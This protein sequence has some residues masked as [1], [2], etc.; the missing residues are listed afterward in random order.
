VQFKTFNE[1]VATAPS[2]NPANAVHLGRFHVEVCGPE[3]R[4]VSVAGTELLHRL[5][6]AVRDDGWR[7]VSPFD[8]VTSVDQTAETL[9]LEMSAR[10]LAPGLD[11]AASA[12]LSLNSAGELLAD[13]R[14]LARRPS[15]YNRI[16]WCL[17]ARTD[18]AVGATLD[19]VREDGAFERLLLPASIVPQRLIGGLPAPIHGPVS[20]LTLRYP[21]SGGAIFEF[22]GDLFETEDQ[23]NWGDATF[24]IYSTPLALRAPHGVEAGTE[25][26]QVVQGQLFGSNASRRTE[27]TGDSPVIRLGGT[28]SPLFPPIGL[29]IAAEASSNDEERRVLRALRPAY[30]RVVVAED[31]DRWPER[32]ARASAMCAEISC[33]LEVAAL[34]RNE[35]SAF[36]ASVG[37]ILSGHDGGVRVLLAREGAASGDG[38][39]VTPDEL[40]QT[41]L[42]NLP[43]GM[44]LAF[45]S[46]LN[47]CEL[48]RTASL[49][50]RHLY[51]RVNAQVHE[52]ESSFVLQTPRVLAEQVASARARWGP[53]T[54]TVS[55]LVF[56]AAPDRRLGEATGAVWIAASMKYLAEAG[57]DG[58]SLFDPGAGWSL[59]SF[60]LDES[61][62]G[63]LTP[64][65]HTVSHL[66]ALRAWRVL[67]CE[68]SDPDSVVGL[69]AESNGMTE[70]VLANLNS[71]EV[72]TTVDWVGRGPQS[73]S[74][75]IDSSEARLRVRAADRSEIEVLLRPYEVVS[76]R[77]GE[78]I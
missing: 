21:Q 9:T 75:D 38:D 19:G 26:R 42:M 28:A 7:T 76:L 20:A 50:G 39:E 72:V 56:A 37:E 49:G 24:K 73:E 6:V 40:Y 74:F 69:A 16:G 59:S 14:W 58:V 78:A 27:S 15:R 77:G 33:G 64:A 22:A 61:A 10:Y 65:A 18:L 60:L 5:H 54:L 1:G 68:S 3:F 23:R 62:V 31:E 44:R 25:V 29:G 70:V 17:L 48:N 4:R 2:V 43:A 13:L 66:C 32:L 55:P 45:G 53:E 57:V 41:A 71:R 12:T 46:N 8:L 35:Q 63:G 34:C 11:V 52:S 30:L 51:W 47:F 36:L 67:T